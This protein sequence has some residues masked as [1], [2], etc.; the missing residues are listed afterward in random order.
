MPKKRRIRRTRRTV[1]RNRTSN[2][3]SLVIKNLILFFILFVASLIF[4]SLSV[5]EIYINLF[6]LLSIL[7]GF[8]TLAFIIVFFIFLVLR[9]IKK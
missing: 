2:K 3:F 1:A 9:L 7:F 4:Y 8:V 5:H 6:L